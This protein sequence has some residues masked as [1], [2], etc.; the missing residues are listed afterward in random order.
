MGQA[1]DRGTR[2]ERIAQAIDLAEKRKEAGRLEDL[3]RQIEY[4]RLSDEVKE[5]IQKKKQQEAQL[6]AM[7]CGMVR[8]FRRMR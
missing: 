1:N 3:Q 8:P 5:R 7:L 6:M 4:E 2:E